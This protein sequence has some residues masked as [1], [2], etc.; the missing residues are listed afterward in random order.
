M[1]EQDPVAQSEVFAHGVLAGVV[2][3]GDDAA[4]HLVAEDDRQLH[5]LA[6]S[7]GAVPEVDVGSAH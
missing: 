3:E 1:G 7:Q 2:T 4:D 6:A 5:G